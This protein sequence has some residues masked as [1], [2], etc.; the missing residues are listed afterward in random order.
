VEYAACMR[1][2]KKIHRFVRFEFLMVVAMKVNVI[3][4]V[5]PRSLVGVY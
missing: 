2:T 3:W 5:L 1:D 4:D